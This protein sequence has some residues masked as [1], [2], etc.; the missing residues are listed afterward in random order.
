MRASSPASH[1]AP[2]QTGA[3][4][5]TAVTPTI[6]L[7]L[8][9]CAGV[10]L[11]VTVL[12]LPPAVRQVAG[13]LRLG[14]GDV[15]VLIAI[16]SLLFALAAAPGG[17]LI[18]RLGPVRS[19]VLGLAVNAAGA[20][21]RGFTREAGGLEA[22]TAMMALGIAVMQVAMPSLVRLWLGGQVGFA[23]A[24]YTFGLLVGEI[25][26]VAWPF[27]LG[28]LATGEPWRGQL[29][30]WAIPVVATLLFVLPVAAPRPARGSRSGRLWPDWRRPALIETGLL[31]G[32]V[33]AT[34]FGLNGFLPI[35]LARANAGERVAGVLLAL[36]LAQLP[37]AFLMMAAAEHLVGRRAV[38]VAASAALVA[39][40][41]AMALWPSAAPLASA[42]VAGFCLALLL[43]L[44]LT[45][46][47][48]VAPPEALPGLT[49]GAFTIGYGLAVVMALA[50]G[51]L[52]R[53]ATPAVGAAPIVFAA[54]AVAVIGWRLARLIQRSAAADRGG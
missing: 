39:S 19:L 41:A 42:S 24:V 1:D 4:A 50:T 34:Y 11:R 20:V 48:L 35:W 37:A 9:W 40:T 5:R 38:Y 43:A 28:G 15:G 21:A 33:N 30:V 44:A 47:P 36:N 8:L 3:A 46:P 16:P 52:D 13:A 12:A 51:W 18:S 49:A 53:F 31:V 32:A 27:P 22:A 23:T 29:A 2:G 25:V 54:A 14:G 7:T 6:A 26:P 10:S 45:V 17:S